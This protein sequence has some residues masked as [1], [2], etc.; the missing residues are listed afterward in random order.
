MC[1]AVETN[2]NNNN[3]DDD[4]DN[5][6]QSVQKRTLRTRFPTRNYMAHYG[7]LQDSLNDADD[8][9][10]EDETASEHAR[11]RS[12]CTEMILFV[13]IYYIDFTMDFI[14]VFAFA[15]IWMM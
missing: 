8:A 11:R 6:Q 7:L 15:I 5:Q 10:N 2:N 3:D 13:S 4:D 14:K 12:I 9:F 1:F